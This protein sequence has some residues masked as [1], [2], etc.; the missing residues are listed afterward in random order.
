MTDP[1]ARGE[2]VERAGAM[3]NAKTRFPQR[4]GRPDRVHTPHRRTQ[5]LENRTQTD[6]E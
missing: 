5:M 1:G 4:L 2:P 6:L 3:E